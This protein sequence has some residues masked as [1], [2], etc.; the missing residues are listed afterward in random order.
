MAQVERVERGAT[1]AE[2]S[3]EMKGIVNGSAG[4]VACHS[5]LDGVAV[6]V[7]TKWNQHEMV[8]DGLPND[9]LDVGWKQ[10]G[11]EW[12]RG[13][14]G[15]EFGQAVGG[16]VSLEC[17]LFDGLETRKGEGVMG[18]LLEQRRDE[19]GGIKAGFH[20]SK[21]ADLGAAQVSLLFEKRADI[22]DRWRNLAGADENS[23]FLGENWCLTRRA[24]TNAVSLN[25]D[26]QIVT[27]S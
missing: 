12:H 21:A 5:Q 9:E 3:D 27:R 22:P 20:R 11:F 18:V 1:G 19:N 10:S 8:E 4:K 26:F 7:G 15:E 6:V 23:T 2:C 16:E 17:A 24:K 13:E 25:G 14:R